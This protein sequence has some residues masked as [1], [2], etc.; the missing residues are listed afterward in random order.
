MRPELGGLGG[1]GDHGQRRAEREDRGAEA[2]RAVERRRPRTRRAGRSASGRSVTGIDRVC[3]SRTELACDADAE[4]ER[5]EQQ[6]IGA[7]IE[8]DEEDEE[9]PADRRLGQGGAPA[10]GQ[11]ASA[12]SAPPHPDGD[13]DQRDGEH[14]RPTCRGRSRRSERAA[15]STSMILFDFS[16]SR[17]ESSMPAR[18]TVSMKR[19]SWP[20]AGGDRPASPRARL[21]IARPRPARSRPAATA[22]P[23][24]AS[25]RCWRA[26]SRISVI[27]L[28]IGRRSS[29]AP[30]RIGRSQAAGQDREDPLVRTPS[31]AWTW[32]AGIAVRLVADESGRPSLAEAGVEPLAGRARSAAKSAWLGDHRDR[33][34]G[35]PARAI[36]AGHA[37]EQRR[38]RPMISSG[39]IRKKRKVRDQTVATK[40]RRAMT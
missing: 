13:P 19:S 30:V 27:C 26:S 21:R 28:R 35:R 29:I 4:E 37:A 7:V 24:A 25:A 18:S 40:S 3:T 14:R 36:R 8:Q 10:R 5:S 31:S 32:R 33:R 20:D 6:I 16:S 34:P 39:P 23:A 12:A 22:R 11:S 17:L 15:A 38:E 1:A 9:R 2:E